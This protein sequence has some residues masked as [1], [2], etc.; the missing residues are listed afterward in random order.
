MLHS[1]LAASTRYLSPDYYW[2]TEFW[3]A[4]LSLVSKL[5]LGLLLYQNVLRFSSFAAAMNDTPANNRPLPPSPP[6]GV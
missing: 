6:P 5:F 1:H 3:Y 4:F 2:K